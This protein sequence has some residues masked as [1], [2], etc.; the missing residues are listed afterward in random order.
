MRWMLEVRVSIGIY[1]IIRSARNATARRTTIKSLP[2]GQKPCGSETQRTFERVCK[3]HLRGLL[4][5]LVLLGFV[6]K[7]I[8]RVV[9]GEWLAA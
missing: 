4:T 5:P 9:S 7:P 6:G 3:V 1:I 2:S 8:P